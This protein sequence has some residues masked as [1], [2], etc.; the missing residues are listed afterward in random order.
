SAR[1]IRD[2]RPNDLAQGLFGL[3]RI[4][5]L[6]SPVLLLILWEFLVRAGLLDDRVFPAPA[7]II[8]TFMRLT[9]SGQLPRDVGDTMGRVALGFSM[10]AVPG[11]LLGL[12]MGLSRV[13]RSFFKPII[14]ALYPIPKIAILPL[15]ILIFGLGEMSK[16][17][18]VA[19]GVIFVVSINTMG[20]VMNIDRIYIDV[21]RNFRADRLQ[22]Y[23]T[24]ALP[25]AL[26]AIFTG[27]QL[28]LGIALM[29]AIATEFVAAKSG[30]GY[31]IWNSWQTFSVEEM[32]CGLVVIAALGFMMQLLLDLLQRWVIPWKPELH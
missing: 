32:Y 7:S 19:S 17:V 18:T 14:A 29:T 12:V 2:V 23:R 3:D 27:L 22:F 10:G 1:T 4:I 9:L 20:G 13:T 21:G 26:P 16:Y 15:I 30:I 11:L 8:G 31:L 5:S 25:G 6:F 28:S 24:V